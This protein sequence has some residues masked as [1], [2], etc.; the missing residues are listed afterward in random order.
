MR[1]VVSRPW[2]DLSQF[3]GSHFAAVLLLYN[4]QSLL[5]LQYLIYSNLSTETFG[6][7][8]VAPHYRCAECFSTEA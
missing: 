1:W 8:V 6:A 3:F 7:A 2:V 5:Q 4:Q